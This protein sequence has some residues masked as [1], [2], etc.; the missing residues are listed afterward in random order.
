M[1][2]VNAEWVNGE[3]SGAKGMFP[4][5]FVDEV[6]DGLPEAAKEGPSTSK[7]VEV[8]IQ[9]V[10]GTIPDSPIQLKP[11]YSVLHSL[12]IPRILEESVIVL[13]KVDHHSEMRAGAFSI[14]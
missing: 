1:S 2:R 6:P 4:T 10:N 8:W 3:L 12:D 11:V 9:L 5:D 13:H 14:L 7:D